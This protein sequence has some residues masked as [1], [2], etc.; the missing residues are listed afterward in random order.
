MNIYGWII[1]AA[2][3]ISYALE[4]ISSRLNLHSLKSEPP[5]ELKDVFDPLQYKKSQEYTSERTRFGLITATFDLAVLLMF[6]FSG[7]F[8]ALDLFIR[9]LHWPQTFA[10]VAY[11]GLL[12]LGL[13]CINL[14]FKIYST[15]VIEEKFGFNKTTW[16]LFILDLIKGMTVSA[17]LG[18]PLLVV[19]LWF[20]EAAGSSAWLYGWATVT[21]FT[22]FVQYIAPVWIMPFFN[23]FT[24]LQDG[25]LKQAIFNYANSV[26]YPLKEIVI[27]DGSKRSAKANAFFTGWGKNKRIALFDTLLEK[28][29]VE[30]LV[31]IVAHEVGHFKL[32]HIIKGDFLSILNTGIVFYLLSIFIAH[33]G[34]FEAFKMEHVS[35]Y[36]GLIFFGML[37][38]PI[39]MLLSIGMNAVSRKH[40][41]EADRFSAETTGHKMELVAALKKLSAQNLTNL[42][43]HPL[44]VF[45][46]YSHPPLKERVAALK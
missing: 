39:E 26:S 33:Q 30:E 15:F 3:L 38:T 29:N 7:G 4:V 19:I 10:G 1:L 27:M 9:Q 24:P 36:A 46:Y 17:L 40:E 31:A 21:A 34:L 35:A 32:K 44:T 28:Y 22:L 18:V 41:F 11:I 8:N 2:L 23:K 12:G 45:L 43:P 6:W 13:T 25:P 20:F 37:Y 14:P 5:E 16:Q 42:T